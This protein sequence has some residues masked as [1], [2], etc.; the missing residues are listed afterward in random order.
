MLKEKK[1]SYLQ[2][3]KHGHGHGHVLCLCP[4]YLWLK[5]IVSLFFKHIGELEFKLGSNI[6]G[7][8]VV[9]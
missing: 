6:K 8:I 2:A 7:W 1:T 9:F 4:L 3:K 5:K